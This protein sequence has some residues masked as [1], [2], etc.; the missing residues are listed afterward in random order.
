MSIKTFD[1]FWLIFHLI[2]VDCQQEDNCHFSLGDLFNIEGDLIPSEVDQINF[3]HKPV[4][5]LKNSYLLTLKSCL[6]V[7]KSEEFRMG[8]FLLKNNKV[9]IRN[10]LPKDGEIFQTSGEIVLRKDK[11]FDILCFAINFD[12]PYSADSFHYLRKDSEMPVLTF[13][14][15]V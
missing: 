13:H 1:K 11:G 14:A 10:L 9:N 2:C 15:N 7:S 4:K 8:P 6:V 5:V 3:S 12:F